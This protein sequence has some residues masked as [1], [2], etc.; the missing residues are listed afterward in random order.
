MIQ[1]EGGLM[2]ITGTSDADGGEP[3]KVGVAIADIMTGMYAVTAILAALE[4]R[5]RDGKGQ[6]IDVPLYHS[7]VAWLANQ[8]QNYLMTGKA[9]VRL[10]NAHPNIVPYQS[11]GTA[12]GHLMIA[13]GNDRQ[14]AAC[15]KC[16]DRAELALDS[17]FSTNEA[18][19]RHRDELI[20]LMTPILRQKSTAEWL[21]AF[22]MAQLPVGRINDLETVFSDAFA[23]EARLVRRLPHALADSVPSVC[24][25]VHFSATPVEYRRAAPILG[26]HTEEVLARDLGYSPQKIAA[27]RDRGTI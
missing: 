27:L 2:S 15:M 13:V 17:R 24:N 4:S 22:S 1:A 20:S 26:E 5:H 10:G 16:L 8:A 21:A 12:D 25:P 18:R 7:Q 3:Q 14:F 19:V 23:A 9:P 6:H 11:F